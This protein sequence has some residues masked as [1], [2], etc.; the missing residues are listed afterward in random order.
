MPT[1]SEIAV[2]AGFLLLHDWES[3][4]PGDFAKS[5][6]VGTNEAQPMSAVIQDIAGQTTTCLLV[7]RRCIRLDASNAR[8]F[9]GSRY[10]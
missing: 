2:E 4:G 9:L 7:K 1:A 3:D 8:A 6:E 5:P 10:T